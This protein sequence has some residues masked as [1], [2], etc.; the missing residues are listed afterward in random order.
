MALNKTVFASALKTTLTTE[1]NKSTLFKPASYSTF[2][3]TQKKGVD[4]AIDAF[5]TVFSE[6][7]AT[8]VVDELTSNAVVSTPNLTLGG[9]VTAPGTIS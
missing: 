1:M 4:D 3:A 5:A 2:D 7:I 6:A 8:T 9:G